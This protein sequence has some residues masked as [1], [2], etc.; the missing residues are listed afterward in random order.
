[1][2]QGSKFTVQEVQEF[3]V[4]KSSWTSQA[5]ELQQTERI[6]QEIDGITK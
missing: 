2:V 5:A 4:F 6:M 3:K 1:M